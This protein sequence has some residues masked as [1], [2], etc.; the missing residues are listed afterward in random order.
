MLQGGGG[1]GVKKNFLLK[2]AK[3]KIQTFSI[4]FKVSGGGGGGQGV[5]FFLL[6]KTAKKIVAP[7]CAPIFD[8]RPPGPEIEIGPNKK[9][10][11]GD[12]IN[13]KIK[14]RTP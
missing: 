13:T 5:N 7:N 3:K 9:I 4:F 6:Q 11:P 8:P 10:Y 1:G 12:S 2:G 14:I